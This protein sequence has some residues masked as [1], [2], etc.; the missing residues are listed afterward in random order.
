ML[1]MF[2]RNTI[3]K[4]AE[5]EELMNRYV[6]LQADFNNFKKRTEKEK[7]NSYHFAAQEIIASF[8]SSYGQF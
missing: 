7:E 6:R 5:Y 3:V 8:T 1:K 2:W 4:I